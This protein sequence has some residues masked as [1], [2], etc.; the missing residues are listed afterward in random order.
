VLTAA[1]GEDKGDDEEAQDMTL[2]IA[3]VIIDFGADGDEGDTDNKQGAGTFTVT[4]SELAAAIGADTPLSFATEGRA[5]DISETT[6]EV[7]LVGPAT[8]APPISNDRAEV[9]VVT[10]LT[11]AQA[12]RPVEFA[13]TESGLVLRITDGEGEPLETLLEAEPVGNDD[14]I[15]I[16]GSS[17]GNNGANAGQQKKKKGWLKRARQQRDA[18]KALPRRRTSSTES[19]SED[20]NEQSSQPTYEIVFE[21][22]DLPAVIADEDV[23]VLGVADFNGDG[24]PDVVLRSDQHLGSTVVFDDGRGGYLQDVLRLS[25]GPTIVWPPGANA[26]VSGNGKGTRKA[27]AH[28]AKNS[29]TFELL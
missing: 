29:N 11:A 25:G 21:K 20:S 26:S 10:S 28:V 14:P 27:T 13:Y 15:F 4:T 22:A 18:A 8:F 23:I 5:F 7:V 24:L 9:E 16:G 1:E 6:S 17:G 12:D 2:T 3:T 19:D